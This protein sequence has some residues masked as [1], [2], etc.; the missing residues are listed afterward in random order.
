MTHQN[1]RKFIKST[2]AISAATILSP[3]LAFAS[4]ANSA[5]RMGIIGC[6]NRGTRVISSMSEHTNINIMAMADLFPDKLQSSKDLLDKRNVEKGFSK[7]EKSNTYIGPE[8]YLRLLENTNLDAVLI[9]SPAYTHAAFLEAAVAAGKHVYC[10]KPVAPDVEGCKRVERVGKRINGQLS[11]AVGF[12]IRFASPYV[13]MISRIHRGDIG[14][15]I[16]G[17]LH[18]LSSGV[19]I[20][21][22]GGMSFD[23]AR[24]R[25]QYHFRAL[26]GGILL[27]QGIHILDI[28]NWALRSHPASVMGIGGKKGTPDFGDAWSNFQVLYSYENNVNV[29]LHS[30]QVGP[31]FGDVSVRFLGSKGIAEAHYTGGVFIQGENPWDSGILKCATQELTLEQRNTGVFSSSLHD[32]DA[33]KEI[34]FISSIETGNYLNETSTAVEST[35]SAIMGREAATSNKPISWDESYFSNEKLDPKLN[36]SQFQ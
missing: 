16:S 33:N 14:E 9:S 35:L 11:I 15:I 2:S 5:I 32:A 13:E 25:N 7:I 20:K 4:K 19:S 17:E 1:R 27:D 22:I 34:D 3:S 12:Q 24:I 21:N 8:A 18:Y 26:S 28:C 36:M 6:G 10:E 29:S 31:A 30:T 23:E